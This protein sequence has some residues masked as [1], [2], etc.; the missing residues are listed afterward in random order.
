MSETPKYRLILDHLRE[1]IRTGRF[2]TGR[3][4]P[5][6]ME[7]A[8]KYGVSRPTAVRAMQELQ[9]L[10]LVERRVGSGTYLRNSEAGSTQQSAT[11]GLLVSG[12]GNTE[13]LDPICSEITRAAEA[14]RHIVVRG[15]PGDLSAGEDFSPEQ[16]ETLCRQ[17]IDRHVDGVFFAPLELPENRVEVNQRMAESL[18]RAGI[19]VVLLDRDL[20]DFPQRSDFDLVGIDNFAAGFDLADCLLESGRRHLRF[21]ARPS[22]PATTDLRMAGCREAMARR[23]LKVPRT[24]A[25]FGD[26]AEPAAVKALLARPTPDG[27]ICS[28]DLTAAVL[29]QT[30]GDLDVRVPTDLAVAGFDDVRYATLLSVPLTTM[31]QPCQ[32]L[33][34]VAV[35]TM[36]ER[37]AEPAL[38]P[39]QISLPATLV[40]RRSTARA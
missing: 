3:R 2:Q 22:Y 1:G 13:I 28:N 40:V 39:R 17:Y 16:A 38:P 26:P 5:S 24:W 7:L 37:L 32:S 23:G 10:G 18:T 4:L 31:R 25:R 14:H 29:M 15:T 6:E 20:L 19:A 8:R 12:L 35:R 11:F 21:F 30:L 34:T 33:G 27:I 36:L 9:S